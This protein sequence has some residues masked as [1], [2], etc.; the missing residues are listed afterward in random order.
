M[1]D[2]IT[3]LN[4]REATKKFDTN[5]KLTAAQLDTLLEAARLAPSSYGLQPWKFIVVSDPALR[6]KLRAASWDQAQV[7]DASHLIVLAAQ[8]PSEVLV[9]AYIADIAQTRGASAEALA[10]FSQM[11]K[12][13]IAGMDETARLMWA[14]KQVYIALGVLLT[15]A[16]VSGIDACPMEGFDVGKY[17]EILGLSADGLHTTVILPVGFRSAEE[18]AVASK[19]VRF[20]KDLVVMEK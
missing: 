6:A 13:A 4:W 12:G 5:K 7:T 17:D 2:I 1:N 8:V 20:A 19:K 10:G 15:A 18:A 9:D 3:A 11:L 14:Q 16:A